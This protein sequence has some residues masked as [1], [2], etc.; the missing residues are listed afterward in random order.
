M[1]ALTALK[2]NNPAGCLAA[3]GVLRI[4]YLCGV[5][6][7]LGFNNESTTAAIHHTAL[8]ETM[9]IDILLGYLRTSHENHC[10][11][12]PQK[13]RCLLCSEYAPAL[14]ME[15]DGEIKKTVFNRVAGSSDILALASKA[16]KEILK[17]G[18]GAKE[19][20]ENIR[21]ALFGPWLHNDKISAFGWNPAEK[22]E[23]ARIPGSKVPKKLNHRTVVGANW[24]AFE[25]LPLV[26]P[27]ALISGNREWVYP[28]PSLAN[29]GE[30]AALMYGFFNLSEENLRAMGISVYRSKP[31]FYSK[32]ASCFA[33]SERISG[34]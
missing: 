28:L 32:S 16:R 4:L 21:E 23:K 3:Y 26:A 27:L 15:K 31:E 1:I 17:T 22:K 33:T 12:V 7:S 30:A 24:L 19:P 13:G 6:A 2:G 5:D 29:Y 20:A 34:V 25:S 14:Y 8:D 9:L 11:E 10:L 18:R